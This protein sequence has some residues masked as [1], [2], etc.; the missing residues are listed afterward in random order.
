MAGDVIGCGYSAFDNQ[1]YWTK[2]GALLGSAERS[3]S[4][5]LSLAEPL[6]PT[7]GS[8]GGMCACATLPMAPHPWLLVGGL[9]DG[10]TL[11]KTTLEAR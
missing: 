4:K 3:S 8:D 2:N 11:L 1:I 10:Q 5:L 6:Y 9:Q 7:V